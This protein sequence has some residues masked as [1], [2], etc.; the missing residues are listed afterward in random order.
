MTFK[1][2]MQ[3]TR[4]VFSSEL[5][6]FLESIGLESVRFQRSLVGIEKHPLTVS[7]FPT[8]ENGSTFEQQADNSLVR[9]TVQMFC[10]QNA[11]EKGLVQAEEYYSALLEFI[12]SNTF[13]ASSDL[14]SSV[15][16]RMDEGE[17]VNGAIFNV[18]SRI[19]SNTDFG[20]D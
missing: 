16:C 11:T 4:D 13:G 10:N 7:V 14:T 12:Q 15:L 17:V 18:T 19:S 8:A 6:P 5:N 20:W 3:E 9:F 2:F 1:Q